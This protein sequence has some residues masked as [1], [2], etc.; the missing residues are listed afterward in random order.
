LPAAK[1]GTGSFEFVIAAP[2]QGPGF[3]H[4]QSTLD[5]QHGSE[6]KSPVLSRNPS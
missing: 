3:Q 1:A 2:D 4:P 6:M 5:R